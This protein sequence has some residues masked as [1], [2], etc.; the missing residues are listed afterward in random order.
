MLPQH[1]FYTMADITT[2][3]SAQGRQSAAKRKKHSTRVDLTPMVDLGFLLITFFIFTTSLTLP[4]AMKLITPADGPTMDVPSSTTLTIF[5]MDNNRIFYYHGRLDD[6]L[7]RG[8][9]G[10]TNYSEQNGIGKLLRDKQA[11][12]S[13]AGKTSKDLLLIIKPTATCPYS[14]IVQMLDEVLINGISRYSLTETVSAEQQAFAKM[15]VP[16]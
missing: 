8:L 13:N 16:L 11:A 14:S 5:P 3:A 6:A 2:N 15:L 7:S 12:L 1:L 10:Y 9:Y 4:R